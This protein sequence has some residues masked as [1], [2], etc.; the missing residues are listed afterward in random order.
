VETAR[1]VPAID[2]RDSLAH[3]LGRLRCVCSRQFVPRR[4]PWI[5][6]GSIPHE[7]RWA[8]NWVRDG[9]VDTTDQLFHRHVPR[10]AYL[11]ADV[12]AGETGDRVQS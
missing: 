10:P 12:G 4:L 3:G 11:C 6:G 7:V 9:L 8:K 2:L 5:F 1:N